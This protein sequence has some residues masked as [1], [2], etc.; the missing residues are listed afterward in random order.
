MTRRGQRIDEDA[1]T[2]V[3]VLLAQVA[4]HHPGAGEGE[5]GEDADGVERD[6]A[7]SPMALKTMI[8]VS[9]T[10][11]ST[12]MPL[13]KASRWPRLVSWRGRYLSPA[14]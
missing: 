12:M 9:D 11:P 4:R 8:R 7:R 10:T 6:R 13:E 1:A 5:A 2:P 3:P 14:T